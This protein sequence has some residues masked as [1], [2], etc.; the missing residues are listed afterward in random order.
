MDFALIDCY[1]TIN[2]NSYYSIKFNKNALKRTEN[3][4]VGGSIPPLASSITKGLRIPQ[5]LKNPFVR[6]FVRKFTVPI[7][8]L[9]L[10]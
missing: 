7:N 3:P 6:K 1:S 2:S 5:V 8:L 9:P 4:C 10:I